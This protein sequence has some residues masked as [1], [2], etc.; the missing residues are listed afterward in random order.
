MTCAED[1]D[2]YYLANRLCEYDL[3][4]YM[5]YLRQPEQKDRKMTTLR[6]IVKEMLLGLQVL[7]RAGVLHR[8]IKPRNVLMG[9]NIYIFYYVSF[10]CRIIIFT[11]DLEKFSIINGSSAVNGCRQNESPNS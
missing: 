6:R 11:V 1:A 10:F 2:F 8:D 4:D 9:I 7:H 3:V 5:E